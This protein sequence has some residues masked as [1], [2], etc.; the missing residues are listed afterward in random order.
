MGYYQCE[1]GDCFLP[2][3]GCC[4][5]DEGRKEEPIYTYTRKVTE[6]WTKHTIFAREINDK[7]FMKLGI[8]TAMSEEH[9]QIAALLE[10][11]ED[12]L[13]DGRTYTTGKLAHHDI[14]LMQCGIG[15]VNA[16]VGAT[17]LIA[18]F[19]P[20]AIINSG[21]A[22]GIDAKLGVMDV[23]VGTETTYH[24][25][26]CGEGNLYGQVQ[27]LPA[28]FA[29]AEPLLAVAREMA[30]DASIQTK[31][32]TGLICTGDKFITDHAILADIKAQFPDGLAVD[33]ESAAI[34]QVCHL[35]KVPFVSFRI[36]SDTPGVDEHWAQYE[37]FWSE[38][39]HRSFDITKHFILGI[40]G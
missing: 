1:D 19:A 10:Q 21:C 27:G 32:H 13:M 16:A 9:A 17:Q 4:A 23:V 37:N 15:K 33:M 8:I 24:D 22:G 36:I 31:I 40:R 11:R 3:V 25:V 29:G 38:M 14:V 7:N 18:R 28:R 2:N 34:A 5:D 20:E 6:K 30:E 35:E 12:I 39:A 26:W